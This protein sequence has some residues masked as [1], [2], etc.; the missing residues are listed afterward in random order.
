MP[1]YFFTVYVDR[2][3]GENLAD[4]RSKLI[5]ALESITDDIDYVFEDPEGRSDGADD[6]AS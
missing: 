5:R 3:P 4:A 1:D 6:D 2:I